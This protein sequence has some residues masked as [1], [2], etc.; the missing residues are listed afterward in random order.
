[1]ENP[2]AAAEAEPPLENPHA[3]APAET[4]SGEE[5]VMERKLNSIRNLLAANLVVLIL[6]LLGLFYENVQIDR[7]RDELMKMRGD[8]TTAVGQFMPEL[9]DRL[10]S[11]EK[12]MQGMDAKLKAAEDHFVDRMNKELPITMDKY[13]NSKMNDL[14]KQ[15][16][17]SRP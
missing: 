14:R 8:A 6:L 17:A 4:G 12:N 1:L 13:V 16:V 3:T 7:N 9:N 5:A 15:A 10:N 2:Q 11:Y